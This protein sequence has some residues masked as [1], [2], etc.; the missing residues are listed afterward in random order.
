MVRCEPCDKFLK[1]KTEEDGF[2][3]AKK[4]HNFCVNMLRGK[5]TDS[6]SN[7]NLN[8]KIDNF[9]FEKLCFLYYT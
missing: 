8:Y 7:K 4:Q 9:F 5:E 6:F 2:V 3:Y 1:L